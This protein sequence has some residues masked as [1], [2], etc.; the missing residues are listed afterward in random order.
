MNL[1]FWRRSRPKGRARLALAGDFPDNGETVTEILDRVK[2][3]SYDGRTWRWGGANNI[4]LMPAPAAAPPITMAGRQAPWVMT[5]NPPRPGGPG[6][7]R[8]AL[9]V[10]RFLHAKVTI[11]KKRGHADRISPEKVDLVPADR[12]RNRR[13]T[14]LLIVNEAAE[15]LRCGGDT[16]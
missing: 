4:G 11:L 10:T 3:A 2:P 7:T 14:A 9:E 8:Q 6:P 5:V 12:L 15:L 13:T 16:R 1:P